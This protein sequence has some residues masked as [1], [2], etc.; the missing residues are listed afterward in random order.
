MDGRLARSISAALG[1]IPQGTAGAAFALPQATGGPLKGSRNVEVER[2]TPTPSVLKR[3]WAVD[4]IGRIAYI[5]D[6]MYLGVVLPKVV[7]GNMKAQAVS[8]EAGKIKQEFLAVNQ[9]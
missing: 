9:A 1:M 2:G 3:L 5:G 6:P 7:A 8:D 4:K